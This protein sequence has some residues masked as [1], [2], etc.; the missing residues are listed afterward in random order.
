MT[1]SRCEAVPVSIGAGGAF[2]DNRIWFGHGSRLFSYELP[3]ER[4]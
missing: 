1:G 4:K 2:L 3:E